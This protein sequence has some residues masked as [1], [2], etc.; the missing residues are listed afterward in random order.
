M[1]ESA[2]VVIVDFSNPQ[3]PKALCLRAYKNWDF[4]KGHL[5]GQETRREA[6]LRETREE[7]GLV[8]GDYK[9]SEFY[10]QS[11]IYRAGKDN[12]Q[13]TYFLA[14]RTSDTQPT[15]PVNPEIG[16]PEHQEWC[17]IPVSSLHKILPPRLAPVVDALETWC[18]G[19]S[20]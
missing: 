17:W 19:L 1:V 18:G 14:E 3:D 6:A 12:K 11:L 8:P 2:G 9:F 16:K 13:V 10:A 4:P 7:T 5:D 20:F 15:L